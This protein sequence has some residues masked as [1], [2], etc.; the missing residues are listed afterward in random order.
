M[1]FRIC[2]LVLKWSQTFVRFYSSKC[3]DV[4]SFFG[5]FIFV[6]AKKKVGNVYAHAARTTQDLIHVQHDT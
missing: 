1:L 3:F 5:L 4:T 2:C 6:F